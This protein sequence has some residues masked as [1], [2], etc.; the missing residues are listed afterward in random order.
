MKKL[1]ISFLSIATVLAVGSITSAQK[2]YTAASSGLYSFNVTTNAVTQEAS[3]KDQNISQPQGQ[4]V[5]LGNGV[6]YGVVINSP[7]MYGGVYKMDTA[8]KKVTSLYEF[9]NNNRSAAGLVRAN[10]GKLYTLGATGTA[11]STGIYAFD[12]TNNSYTLAYTITGNTGS[13]N[14]AEMVKAP[15]GLLYGVTRAGGA[16]NK[17]ILFSFDPATAA[18]NN[19]HDFEMATGTEPE[20]GM[21]LAKNGKLY[22]GATYGGANDKGTLYCF[23]IAAGTY[24]K[25]Y[26]FVQSNG[27][28]PLSTMIQASNGLLYGVTMT[29]GDYYQGVLYSFDLATNTYTKLKAFFAGDGYGPRK[30]PIEGKPGVLYGTTNQGG[31]NYRGSIYQYEIGSSSWSKVV[32]GNDTTYGNFVCPFFSFDQL[33]TGIS[34]PKALQKVSVYP[35]PVSDQLHIAADVNLS[36]YELINTLGQVVKKGNLTINTVDVEGLQKG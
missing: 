14:A 1:R 33:T 32:D 10:N 24:T 28:C 19:L 3:F 29:G 9:T 6:L 7:S 27:E 25:L 35:N 13:N 34:A 8:T 30:A 36:S 17:G 4:L 15:N 16:N 11:N 5:H 26:D 22:G 23:D 2:I 31:K 20:S 18:F 12:P 21:L